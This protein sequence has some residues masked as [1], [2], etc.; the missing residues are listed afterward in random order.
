MKR[1]AEKRCKA[2]TIEGLD[3]KWKKLGSDVLSLSKKLSWDE[4][5][6]KQGIIVLRNMEMEAEMLEQEMKAEGKKKKD[7]VRL[8]K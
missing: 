7:A 2:E 4:F 8:G 3:K 5:W 1:K 6:R